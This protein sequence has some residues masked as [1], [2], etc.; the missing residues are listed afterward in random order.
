VL[1]NKNNRVFSASVKNFLD[2]SLINIST[3]FQD[4][5]N[6]TNILTDQEGEPP[7]CNLLNCPRLTEMIDGLTEAVRGLEKT[8]SS[9]KSKELGL[10]RIKLEQLLKKAKNI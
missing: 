9:F 3:A 4:V 7:V 1:Q 10:L 2:L 5:K 6:L 8:K